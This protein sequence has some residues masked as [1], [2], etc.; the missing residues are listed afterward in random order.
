MMRILP[1]VMHSS[2]RTAELLGTVPADDGPRPLVLLRVKMDIH[3]PKPILDPVHPFR[4]VFRIRIRVDP[5]PQPNKMMEPDPHP[6]A[7]NP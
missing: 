2:R 3:L 1:V 5:Y 4:S 7:L 6:S